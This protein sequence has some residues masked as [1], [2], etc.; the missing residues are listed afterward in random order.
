[1]RRVKI[2]RKKRGF[3]YNAATRN[4]KA[5][6]AFLTLT[7]ILVGP[8]IR[9]EEAAKEHVLIQRH[10]ADTELKVIRQSLAIE[11]T[12]RQELLNAQTRLALEAKF[13][14]DEVARILGEPAPQEEPIIPPTDKNGYPTR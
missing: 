9:Q 4:M 2:Q 7:K 14:K 10:V 1:M 5:A 6:K 8:W 12:R 3:G 13:G 11:Q